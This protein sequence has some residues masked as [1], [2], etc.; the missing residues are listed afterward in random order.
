MGILQKLLV[1]ACVPDFVEIFRF[2]TS[3]IDPK[4][5]NTIAAAPPIIT[6]TMLLLIPGPVPWPRNFADMQTPRSDDARHP[7]QVRPKAPAE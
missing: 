7:D 2:L 4:N 5:A 6:A 1:S 3:D